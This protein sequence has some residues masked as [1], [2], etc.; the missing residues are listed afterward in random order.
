MRRIWLLV[1]SLWL[2]AAQAALQPDLSRLD[3]L[4]LHVASPAV[5]AK[6]I[7]AA[8][9]VKG[10]GPALFAVTVPLPVDLS[11]G[12]WDE[13]A[14]VGRWRTRVYSAG[15]QA[16][17]MEFTRFHVPDGAS[18]W[19]Y[20]AA[21]RTVQGPYDARNH[22]PEGSLWTAL[23]PGETAVLELR[24]PSVKRGD[25]ELALGRLGHAYKNARDL[26][27][28]G[29]CNI[30]TACPL[31]DAWRD[32]IRSVV[33]LQIPSG[34]NVGLCSGTLINNLAQDDK[35][36]VMTAD[37]C[38]IRNSSPPSGVVVYW[39]FQN[40]ACN[41]AD[42]APDDQTQTGA[43]L[44]ARDEATDLSLLELSQ[45]P[46]AAFNVYYAGWDA[47]GTGGDSGVSIHHPSGDAKK[48]TEFTT[49][50]VQSSIRLPGGDFDIPAWRVTWSQGTT[51]QGSSGSG[52]WNQDRRIVGVL[53]GGS[54]SC[55]Q[56]DDPDFYARL[57]RQW[58]A[59]P[60]AS[61]QLKA[62][63]DAVD[64]GLRQV[65]GKEAGA[66]P[67]PTPAPSPTPTPTASPAPTAS[68]GDGGGGGGG[69]VS[70]WLLVLLLAA[71]AG[72]R[73]VHGRRSGC[74]AYGAALPP[75]GR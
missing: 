25:V 61:G 63:L 17:L 74:A 48:V 6:A 9:N 19:I 1:L 35:A 32:E 62:W 21:G 7:E 8:E 70:P 29:P 24:V 26:G 50:L 18:L 46:S 71:G 2:P 31:G 58:T 22:S 27:D 12:V 44:R 55:A 4:P 14:G 72:R 47:S 15:A 5:T 28:S 75:I 69:T 66:G 52:L 42:N 57:D 53:S 13:Q 3:A 23:V 33:K 36:Y 54:A 10:R 65:A 37:H 45:R 39:N 40:S 59:Q 60:Q 64:T 43:V 34:D 56:S 11:G 67:V 38:G 16:L 20:D 49:P 51:E 73:L 68:P 41:G 30:D